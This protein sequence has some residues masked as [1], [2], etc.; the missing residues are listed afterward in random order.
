MVAEFAVPKPRAKSVTPLDLT[1]LAAS[2]ARL[3]HGAGSL[4]QTVCWPSDS[5]SMTHR[6]PTHGLPPAWIWVRPS[7]SPPET[8]VKPLGALS[9][10]IAALTSARLLERDVSTLT[11]S[12]NSTTDTRARSGAR[13]NWPT[14][15][16]AK[17]FTLSVSP[18]I[19]PLTSSTSTRSRSTAHGS[20][21]SGGEGGV[22]G[23]GGDGVGGTEGAAAATQWWVSSGQ[24]IG[25]LT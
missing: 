8:E 25:G 13:S 2:I 15:V 22:G 23:V 24:H 7:V 12:E 10:L 19:D 5:T 18:A 20:G 11:W 17:F 14:S 4:P 21:S 6:G 9:L 16:C 1:V 3:S